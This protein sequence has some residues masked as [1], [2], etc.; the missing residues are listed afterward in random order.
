MSIMMHGPVMAYVAIKEGKLCMVFGQRAR[1]ETER[2]LDAI[3]YGKPGGNEHS[4]EVDPL[5]RK[6]LVSASVDV[7]ALFDGVREAAPLWDKH[8][9]ALRSIALRWRLPVAAAV[10]VEGGA[11]RLAVR[12]PPR[13]LAEAAARIVNRLATARAKERGK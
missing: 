6:R 3:A 7:A 11:L 8:G 4:A 1:E 2:F 13:M 9:R 12:F 5:F 10:T